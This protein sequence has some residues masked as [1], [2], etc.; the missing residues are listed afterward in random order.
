[1]EH[2]IQ[3]IMKLGFTAVVLVIVAAFLA[4]QAFRILREYERAVIFRLGKLVGAKG[5][6]L[7]LLIPFV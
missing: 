4:P 7:V 3:A 2:L 5:P 1:M 6:G